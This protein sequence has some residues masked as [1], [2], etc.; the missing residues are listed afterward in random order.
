MFVEHEGRAEIDRCPE[1]GTFF[2]ERELEAVL[3]QATEPS[4]SPSTVGGWLRRLFG[5]A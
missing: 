4:P 2:D 5:R 1:H 3:L